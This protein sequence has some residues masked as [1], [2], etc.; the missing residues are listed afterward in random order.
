MKCFVKS[1]F[2]TGWLL[3]LLGLINHSC[4]LR[5]VEPSEGPIKTLIIDAGHGGKDPGAVGRRH[6]EKHLALKVA[7]KLKAIMQEQ[8]PGI[9]VELTRETDHFVPL[10]RRAR[11]AQD[12]AG[13]FFVSIHLNASENHETFGTETYVMGFN[14]GQE[15]DKT[16]VAEN[17]AILFE[18]DH[19]ELYGGFDPRSPEG[20]IYFK[21]LKDAFREESTFL[22]EQLQGE[23]REYGGRIDRGVKQGPFVVLYLSG[24]PAI[25]TEVGF[26]S[27]AEEEKFLASEAGQQY[28]ATSIYRSIKT[29]NQSFK[30][31][32]DFGNR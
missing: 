20:H 31:K 8:L 6:Y 1:S 5:P 17:E 3:C 28:L 14:K 2:W 32:S 7:L 18:D 10:Y 25:L 21:L 12:R 16:I 4:F 19:Q 9:K 29:Y 24:M 13:D 23:Y 30:R 26:I 22:A 27:N 11:M 15:D